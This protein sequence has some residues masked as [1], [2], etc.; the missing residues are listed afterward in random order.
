MQMTLRIL[1]GSLLT[2]TAANVVA[3]NMTVY[4]NKG[5]QALL[6][7]VNPNDSS[8]KINKKTEVI[9]YRD[10]GS[11]GR[12]ISYDSDY[13]ALGSSKNTSNPN[14]SVQRVTKPIKNSKVV[15][16]DSRQPAFVFEVPY[17]YRLPTKADNFDDWKTFNAPNH[18]KADFNGDGIED[19]AYILPKKGSKLG[20][21]VF[22]SIN[23]ANAGIQSGRKSQI[24]KLTARD[25]MQPQSFAIELA[26]PSD[27]I[28]ETACG[29][30][31]W[32][33]ELGEPAEI[34]VTN[35]TIMFCYIE[36]ACS[37]YLW[38]SDKLVF[39]EIHFSD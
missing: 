22:V 7:N 6:A 10:D 14:N 13:T 15:T 31:Y 19:E 3:A 25:D 2:L 26:E 9:Y 39:K 4:K 16:A 18:L 32:E 20:Y 27:E 24:F 35:P 28:W 8:A 37:M 21:G 11:S 29:K 30:G 23:K 34:K 33:C 38:N 36:S 17:G 12:A 5:G 1:L